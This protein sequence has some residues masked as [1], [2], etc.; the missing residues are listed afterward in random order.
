MIQARHTEFDSLANGGATLAPQSR[1]PL[2]DSLVGEID[3]IRQPEGEWPA[4]GSVNVS[5]LVPVK[6][7]QANIVECLRHLS[8]AKHLVVV[9]S[10]STDLTIPMSQAMGADVYQFHFSKSGWPRKKNWALEN[11]RWQTP[12]V[13]IMDAD[14]HVTPGLAAEIKAVVENPI[15]NQPGGYWINRRFIFMGRWLRHSGYYPSWNI[16][17]LQHTAGRYERI[18][19][20]GDTGSGDNEVHEHIVLNTGDA[21][22]LKHDFLHYAYPDLMT[23]VEKH[24]RYSSWEAHVHREIM[25]GQV[26]SNLFG[27]PV[28]RKR[29][30]KKIVARLPFRPSLRFFYAY[31]LRLGFLDGYPG[32]VMAR[33]LAWYEYISIAKYRE[34]KIKERYAPVSAP[35]VSVT[36]NESKT[37]SKAERVAL[38]H[39]SPWSLRQKIWRQLWAMVQFCLFRPSPRPFNGWRR[40]LLRLFGTKIH[41]SSRISPTVQIEV[42]WHLTIGRDCAIGH[43]AILYCLGAVKIGDRVMISQYSHL[44]AGSHDYND[45]SLPL[46]RP[47]ITVE[48][49]AWVAAEAFVGP[50]VTIKQGA[51]LGAGGVAFKDLEPWTIYVGNPA[52][53]VKTRTKLDV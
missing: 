52:K 49:D 3:P 45:P 9:D 36:M 19:H 32:Y 1:D 15:E 51:I 48:D 14:E 5:V 26:E 42:P 7:E 24:N 46:Q 21:G 38:R 4:V 25:A 33:L 30:V 20:V 43:Q 47:P 6:N 12:W 29:W 50:G 17:L 2:A 39:V 10:Q 31:V 22:H 23:W 41:S 13:L 27:G 18:G 28:A 53:P 11:V 8:W 37:T 35:T 40:M 16:R 44:C 34:M